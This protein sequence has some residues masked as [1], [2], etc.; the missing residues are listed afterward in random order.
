M[1]FQCNELGFDDILENKDYEVKIDQLKDF[2][3][4]NLIKEV[5]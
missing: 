2:G 3:P 5:E 1:N 4:F